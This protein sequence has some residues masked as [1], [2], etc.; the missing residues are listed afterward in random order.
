MNRKK[1]KALRKKLGLSQARLARIVGVAVNTVSRWEQGVSDP[2]ADA[3]RQLKLLA[4]R[5][6]SLSRATLL[7]SLQQTI[8]GTMDKARS[9]G[10]TEEQVRAAAKKAA[11]S[12]GKE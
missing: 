11:E 6:S 12:W 10:C 2:G 3:G 8:L 4:G 9:Y 5:P 1:I 7:S